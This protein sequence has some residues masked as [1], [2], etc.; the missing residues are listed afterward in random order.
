MH[1]DTLAPST[2]GGLVWASA[3]V[4]P[5]AEHAALA[6]EARRAG[7]STLGLPTGLPS[8]DRALNG[9]QGGCLYVLGGAPGAGKTTLALQWA[10]QIAALG[11]PTIYVTFEN[12][13][14]NLALKTI[15]RLARLP[16]G[17]VERGREE[18]VRLIEGI[19]LFEVFADRLGLIHGSE[20]R[21]VEEL[22]VHARRATAA[23]TAGRCLVVVDYLQR[24]AYHERLA[25]L[26][27]NVSVLSSRLRDLAGRLD[28][29]ILALSSLS[30]S[31]VDPDTPTL[32]ALRE[33]GTLEYD[34]DAVLLLAPRREAT[35]GSVARLKTVAGARLLDL[36]IAK[37]RVGE[38]DMRVP[39][40]FNPA[41]S[42][43]EEE[44]TVV[45][46][47]P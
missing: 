21:L 26:P 35:L 31:T 3:L 1:H 33:S 22:E 7:Q 14:V 47:R 28:A 2:T 25:D 42:S 40:L 36:L 16:T 24:M 5:V 15:C 32:D 37:N 20:L 27:E 30:R 29:P 34:A 17:L 44:L 45:G 12:S 23:H 46:G 13:L 38:A 10:S 18:G 6:C 11:T 41:F 39:L 4:G 9:L 43:F 8:I 19:R